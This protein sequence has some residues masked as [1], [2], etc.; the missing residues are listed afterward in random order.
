MVHSEDITY[1]S[2]PLCM[3]LLL[4]RTLI[5]MNSDSHSKEDSFTPIYSD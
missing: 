4:Y 2:L 1:Y 3:S 5:S